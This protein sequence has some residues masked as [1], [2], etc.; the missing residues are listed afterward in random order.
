[1]LT[2]D[3]ALSWQRGGRIGPRTLDLHDPD[4]LRIAGEL[5]EIVRAHEGRRRAELEQALGE[6]VGV[7]T[8]YRILRGLI[9]LLLDQC[10]FEISGSIDPA[11]LRQTVFLK[12]RSHH[13]I[14]EGSA[15]HQEVIAATAEILGCAPEMVVKGLYADLSANH[16][17]TRFEEIAAEQLLERYNLAQAQ[18]LLYRCVEMR[19]SV[20]PQEPAGYRQLFEAIKAHR[21]IHTIKGNSRAGY[22][23]RLNGPVSLFHRSQKYG[24][25]MAVFLPALLDCQSWRMRAEIAGQADRRAFFELSSA[26]HKL[27]T[28]NI[29]AEIGG[30]APIEKFIANWARLGSEW[31][32][33]PS[34]EVVDLGEGA[35]IPDFAL[36]HESGKL[37]YLEILGFWTP[38]YLSERLAEFAHAE[39]KDFILVVSEEMRGTREPPKKLPP[40][41]VVCKAA[42]DARAVKSAAD[43]LASDESQS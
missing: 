42:L 7:G 9:K 23:V 4:Y 43:Q 34:Q 36:R 29:T 32:L 20:E 35:F 38:R 5:I 10:V 16:H 31:M 3:L 40:N 39:F 24:I 8:D 21:L 13:P 22:E 26:E 6:Y 37:V 41:I 18:A 28:E 15:H 11:T 33:E 27:R 19:L 2:S 12:A 30:Q 14:L 17:L 1:V 25:Q